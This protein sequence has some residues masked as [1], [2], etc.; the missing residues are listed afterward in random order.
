MY[1]TWLYFETISQKFACIWRIY[2][3]VISSIE[4]LN[5]TSITLII[6]KSRTIYTTLKTSIW[7]CDHIRLALRLASMLP[8]LEY[9]SSSNQHK[10]FLS[11]TICES[12]PCAYPL[13]KKHIKLV[14]MEFGTSGMLNEGT[15]I[16][17]EAS[18]R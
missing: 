11:T 2:K 4:S 7:S 14:K 16:L 18:V 8:E 1:E 9:S 5:G 6:L 13:R 3:V 12:L 17:R 15:T 10:L